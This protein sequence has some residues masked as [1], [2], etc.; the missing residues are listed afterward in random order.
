MAQHRLTEDDYRAVAEW[1]ESDRYSEREKVAIE[2]A[3]RFV[4]DHTGLDDEF[5]TRFRTEWADEEILDLTV[6]IASF[7]GLGR[8]TQ[9][10]A[11]EHACRLEI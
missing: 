2:Y 7:L 3:E 10:L 1:R 11:P 6:C 4:T 9:V 8:M 5:W